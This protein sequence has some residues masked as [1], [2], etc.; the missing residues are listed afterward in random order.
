MTPGVGATAAADMVLVLPSLLR[1]SG[2]RHWSGANYA[3]V[4]AALSKAKSTFWGI[5]FRFGLPRPQQSGL[6]EQLVVL[7]EDG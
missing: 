6:F 7:P 4:A 5:P 3:N 2:H 1:H